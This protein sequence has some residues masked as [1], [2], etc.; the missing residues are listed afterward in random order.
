MRR[1]NSSAE[2]IA[3]PRVDENELVQCIAQLINIDQDWVPHSRKASLYIR[4]TY[5]AT[6]PTLGVN[7]AGRA[8]LFV[9]LSPVGPYFR[10]G[11]LT[12]V[13]L[14]ADPTYIRAWEYGT[15]NYKLGGNYGPTI[16]IQKEA[17]AQG[18]QQLL[19]LYGANHKVTN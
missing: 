16:G 19:W 11:S 14:M 17:D 6:Q 1:L 3:L 8:L 4:P 7:V 15:G 13:S 2:R 5:I 10:T 12:P 9:I 18:C